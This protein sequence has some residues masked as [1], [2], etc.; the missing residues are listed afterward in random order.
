MSQNKKDP[1]PSLNLMVKRQNDNASTGLG[2]GKLVPVY[3]Q[4]TEHFR[5]KL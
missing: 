2:G 5:N 4:L 1:R 3:S